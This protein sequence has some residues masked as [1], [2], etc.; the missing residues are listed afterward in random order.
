MT[1][2]EPS[3]PLSVEIVGPAGG[4]IG[5]SYPFT[6]AVSPIS[7][8][9]PVEYF[10]QADGQTP[11]TH[12]GGLSDTLAYLW[13]SP[14]TQVITVTATNFGGTVTDTHTITIT[15]VPIAGL[16]ANNDSP[17]LLGTPTTFTATVTAGT[18]VSFTWDFG[19]ESAL[20]SGEWVT[21]SYSIAGT[22]TAT[23]T[24]NNSANQLSA[25]TSVTIL[26]PE[27]Q[28]YLPSIFDSSG[29]VLQRPT[30]DF[31]GRIAQGR[32]ARGSSALASL[33]LLGWA[34]CAGWFLKRKG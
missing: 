3:A 20:Q 24:A 7:T 30:D 26:Q 23:V 10:W 2:L 16:V 15:D 25:S 11:I 17:T 19:D 34:G 4:Q 22:Y 12:T 5:G 1:V 14:G 21:H 31:W 27:S 33:F 32:T 9:L 28:I 8:T 18:N 6:A 13:D 29:E